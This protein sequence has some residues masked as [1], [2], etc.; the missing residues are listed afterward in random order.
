MGKQRGS[1][2]KENICPGWR[3]QADFV[4][5]VKKQFPGV[6]V[7]ITDGDEKSPQD[8]I[9]G[10]SGALVKQNRKVAGLE[11][12]QTETAKN[13]DRGR[14]AHNRKGRQAKATRLVAIRK[15]VAEKKRK[16]ENGFSL[17]SKDRNDIISEIVEK[18]G[19]SRETVRKDIEG[20]M[21]DIQPKK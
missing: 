11:G 21:K 7:N 17:E 19:K 1:R 4:E 8:V 9:R 15:L 2:G 16:T 12:K 3:S 20:V 6:T 10:L 18:F 14:D 13:L 5:E